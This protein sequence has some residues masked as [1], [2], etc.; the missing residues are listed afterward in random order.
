MFEEFEH[1]HGLSTKK[2]FVDGTVW[3]VNKNAVCK[4][5]N[6]CMRKPVLQA[7]LRIVLIARMGHETFQNISY[8]HNFS[9]E[10]E[11]V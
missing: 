8:G 1:S 4:K 10:V 6:K 11:G 9:G 5:K 2:W 7:D 3:K